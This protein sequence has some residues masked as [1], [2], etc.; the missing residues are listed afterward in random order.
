MIVGAAVRRKG[1]SDG[2][3][4]RLAPAGARGKFQADRASAQLVFLLLG[5]LPR[6]GAV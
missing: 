5:F 1:G 3:T 4:G 2:F 6:S